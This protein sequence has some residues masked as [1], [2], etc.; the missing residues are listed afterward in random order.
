M[1]TRL[2]PEKSAEAML[3][4]AILALPPQHRMCLLIALLEQL[5]TAEQMQVV[6]RLTHNIAPTI[7]AGKR[8]QV[9]RAAKGPFAGDAWRTE[10]SL[11]EAESSWQKIME[12]LESYRPRALA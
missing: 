11:D 12:D 1:N 4:T 2:E 3:Q 5:T 6:M 7:N 9:A 10:A 8:S